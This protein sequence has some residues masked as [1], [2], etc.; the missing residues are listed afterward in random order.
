MQR[1]VSCVV[2]LLAMFGPAMADCSSEVVAAM[3]KQHASKAF[4]V[5]TTQ[6]TAEGPVKMTVDYLPPDRMLQTVTGANLP[7]AQ[8]TM[9][10][11]ERAFSGS[12][13]AFEELLPQFTQSVVAEFRR[14]LGKAEN[15]AN[16]ECQG[17]VTFEGKEYL[18]YKLVGAPREGASPEEALARTIYVDAASGLPAFNIV[19]LASGKGEPLMKVS[20]SY[21]ND[22]VI[23][24]PAGAPLQR[25]PQ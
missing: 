17:K 5:E 2:A 25:K 13:G 10:V 7:G 3:D 11:G 6:P 23:E 9:L 16:F 1:V 12:N 19:G 22:I 15:V 14:S 18:G 20:Y 8:Q 21:P 24:A 4:R